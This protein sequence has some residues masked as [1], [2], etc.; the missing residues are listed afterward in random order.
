MGSRDGGD[1]NHTPCTEY[2][3]LSFCWRSRGIVVGWDAVSSA[4]FRGHGSL[5]RK[6]R[7][8]AASQ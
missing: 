1:G 7:N 2:L 8:N 3:G 4:L 6:A 5:Q